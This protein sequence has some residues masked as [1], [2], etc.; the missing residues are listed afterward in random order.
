MPGTELSQ[1]WFT[2]HVST[3]EA[4]IRISWTNFCN[5]LQEKNSVEKKLKEF[6]NSLQKLRECTQTESSQRQELE[7][8]LKNAQAELRGAHLREQV[9]AI[10]R[11]NE[12][13]A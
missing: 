7:L 3:D 6:E 4:L 8:N 13:C 12:T 5:D 11:Q 1:S 10:G 2:E 9:C